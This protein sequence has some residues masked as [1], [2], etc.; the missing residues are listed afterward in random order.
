MQR[1]RNKIRKILEEKGKGIGGFMP[2][3]KV[4]Q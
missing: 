3:L 1:V 2:F 4:G